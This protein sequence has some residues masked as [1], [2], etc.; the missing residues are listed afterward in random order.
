MEYNSWSEEDVGT[1]KEL[2][3]RFEINSG[4]LFSLRVANYL[5]PPFLHT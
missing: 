4:L 3:S 1:I 5:F 2:L